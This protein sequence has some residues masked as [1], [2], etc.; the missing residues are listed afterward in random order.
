MSDAL[1]QDGAAAAESHDD[2]QP[3]LS[4]VPRELARLADVPVELALE[5][6]RV[7]ITI[8]DLLEL[9]PGSVLSLPYASA[10]SIDVRV[11]DECIARGEI[12]SK[13][14]CYGVLL[15]EML[16]VDERGGE[17]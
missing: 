9:A 15:L 7:N 10:D 13:D 16:D 5:L 17:A 4:L 2:S 6:S 8:R 1:L 11:G 3:A 12:T 14:H